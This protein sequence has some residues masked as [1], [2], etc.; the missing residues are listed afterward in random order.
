MTALAATAAAFLLAAWAGEMLRGGGRTQSSAPALLATHL[1]LLPLWAGVAWASGIASPLP[2]V[3]FWSGALVLWLGVRAHL[4]SSILLHLL[5]LLAAEG[6][7]SEGD[8]TARAEARNGVA[9]R[10]SELE[11]AGLV[12]T[13]GGA[14][15]GPRET[16]R[17]T[18]R[19]RRVAALHRLL[20]RHW[21]VS[22]GEPPRHG[23][24]AREAQ[25]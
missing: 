2:V 11:R 1:V 21:P 12:R 13:G 4:E 22:E 6:P 17:P 20:T 3:V 25:P 9:V 7:L 23:T 14:A 16:V 10:L 5:Q 15:V 24:F 8:I 18:P 19:G